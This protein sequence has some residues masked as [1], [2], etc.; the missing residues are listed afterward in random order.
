MEK[1]D[2]VVVGAGPAGST[3]AFVMAK[4]GLKVLLLERSKAAGE[5]NV[6][7]GR[8]YSHVLKRLFSNFEDEA[9][10]ER[11]VVRETIGMMDDSDCVSLDFVSRRDTPRS[12]CSFVARRNR[13]DKWLSEKAEQAGALFVGG[14]KVDDLIIRDGKVCGIVSGSD[15]IEADCVV[16]AE[17]VTAALSRRAGLRNDVAPSQIKVGVKETIQLSRQSINERFSLSDDEGAACVYIG[18]PT[19]FL[20]ASGAFV[21]TNSESI[22]IGVV[23]DPL[24]LSQARI[25]VQEMIEKFRLHPSMERLLSGGKVI[26]YS[27]HMIPNSVP[28]LPS[29]LI[30]DGFLSTGD[31]AG[32]F[33][34]HGFTYRGVDLA[35][36]SGEAAGNAV[37]EAHSL[38]SY[39]REELMRYYSGLSSTVLPEMEHAE[40]TGEVL[41]NERIF[42]TYP[43]IAI[44]F[45]EDMFRINGFDREGAASLLKKNMSGRVSTLRMLRDAYSAYRRM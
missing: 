38:G 43:S 40:K 21:Y 19:S 25:E 27:A 13:F 34:N 28:A 17:G 32:F 24:E 6:F 3:S 20:T 33:I 37:V 5:K 8:I 42:S 1:F 31:A 12:A 2:A 35:M 45:M 15:T 29:N 11:Y 26:E 39:G 4:A 9:P 10:V 44:G 36:A 18:Q 23:V 22:S 30:R 7:G 41:H 16:D 14:T